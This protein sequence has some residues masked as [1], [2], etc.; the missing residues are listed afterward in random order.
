MNPMKYC[1]GAAAVPPKQLTPPPYSQPMSTVSVVAKR[2]IGEPLGFSY[3][4]YWIESSVWMRLRSGLPSASV[5]MKYSLAQ[6][7]TSGVGR[8][9][10]WPPTP[11]NVLKRPYD[12]Q[13]FT[14]H[15][16]IFN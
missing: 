10:I 2:V 6:I 12:C 11:G 3:Q 13:P 7:E 8:H 9:K 16:S 1:D 4:R 5:P 14:S 15:G